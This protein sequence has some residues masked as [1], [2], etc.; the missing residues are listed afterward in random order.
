MLEGA[1]LFNHKTVSVEEKRR[2]EHLAAEQ[3]NIQKLMPKK[4]LE[5]INRQFIFP[6]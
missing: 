6:I 5:P 3:R 2:V 1:I 4:L